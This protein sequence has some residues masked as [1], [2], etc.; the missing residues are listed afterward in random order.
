MGGSGATFVPTKYGRCE[1]VLRAE[2]GDGS[3]CT[4]SV[5]ELMMRPLTVFFIFRIQMQM[6]MEHQRYHSM[7]VSHQ[8]GTPL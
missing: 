3:G 4:P 1:T 6:V 5:V 7:L 2:W 8:M